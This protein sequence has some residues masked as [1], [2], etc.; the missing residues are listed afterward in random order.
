MLHTTEALTN[1]KLH[2]VQR[3]VVIEVEDNNILRINGAAVAVDTAEAKKLFVKL[4][5][6]GIARIIFGK[7]LDAGELMKFLLAISTSGGAFGPYENIVVS[8]VNKTESARQ[9]VVQDMQ[10]IYAVKKLFREML[11]YKNV[12]MVSVDVVVGGILAGIRKSRDLSQLIVPDTGGGN[13]PF[14]HAFNVAL[15]SLF[16]AEHIGIGSALLHD[17]GFAALM[18]DI[19]KTLLPRHVET[20]QDSLDEEGWM[21]MK[22]H[23]IYGAAL[24]S[25]LTKVPDIA[26]VVAF[27]H[28][29]KYD[30]TG[31]PETRQHARKPHLITQIVGIADWYCALISD[32]PHRKPLEAP[33]I[34]GLL[35]GMAG[36]EFNPLLVENLVHAASVNR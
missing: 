11:V 23:P 33:V 29:L 8:L 30:G 24:L 35:A 12:D 19:G 14:V 10:E 13:H 31:Y 21:L 22:K 26:V 17:I 16:Q 4:R 27:E 20:R 9:T 1:L 7:R 18:H 25:S 15:L 28:H 5:Q 2:M 3:K 6:R 36:K 34:L 32:L